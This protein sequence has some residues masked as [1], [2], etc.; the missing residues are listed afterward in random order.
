MI[1][2]ISGLLLALVAL[3]GGAYIFHTVIDSHK[4]MA[5]PIYVTS[6]LFILIGGWIVSEGINE[7][8][9]ACLH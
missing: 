6:V 8:Y 2:I 5:L 9:K 4:W 3:W 1:K 7:M